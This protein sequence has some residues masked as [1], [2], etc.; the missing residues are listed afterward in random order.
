MDE[1]MIRVAEQFSER[2]YGRYPEH[3]PDNGARFR[4]E[5]L[6]PALRG[7]KHVVVVLDGAR[8]LGPSFLEEAFGGLVRAGFPSAEIME[9]ITIR[10]DDDPS[11]V[12]EIRAYVADAAAAAMN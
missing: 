3:G 6:I 2:P 12:D 5:Y 1:A 8:G 9:R 11:Y 4:E 7:A 10:S